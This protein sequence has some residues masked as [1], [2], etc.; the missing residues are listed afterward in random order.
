MFPVLAPPSGPWL[1]SAFVID[2]TS[3][4]APYFAH[5]SALVPPS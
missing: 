5:W 2:C 1:F 3:P 4:Y